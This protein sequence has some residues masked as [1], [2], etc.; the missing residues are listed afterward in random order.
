MNSH[1]MELSKKINNVI[2]LSQYNF[3][4][5]VSQNINF[6]R[7]KSSIR[8]ALRILRKLARTFEDLQKNEAVLNCRRLAYAIEPKSPRVCKEFLKSLYLNGYIA[9]ALQIAKDM[10]FS[11]EHQNLSDLENHE[12]IIISVVADL[13]LSSFEMISAY[14]RAIKY[15]N[16]AKID[17]AIVECGVYKGGGIMAALMACQF[18]NIKGRDIYL[19]DTFEGMPYPD[20]IDAYTTGVSAAEDYMRFIRSDGTSGWVRSALEDVKKNIAMINY[21]ECKLHYTKGLVED[22]IPNTVPRSIALLRLD[23]DFYSSTKHE[24]VHLYPLVEKGGV[25]FID[26]YGAFLGSKLAVDDYF[27]SQNIK[28][29]LIRVDSNVRLYIKN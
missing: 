11:E 3:I 8:A 1:F 27:E 10:D 16:D 22:T 12:K 6:L 24:L 20:Q 29:Y 5:F 21:N 28:P 4:Y 18:L 17:G 26:D 19:Y 13:T 2:A 7:F 25:I 9:E 14:Y 23:T 15:L